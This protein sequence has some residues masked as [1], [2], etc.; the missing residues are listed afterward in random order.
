[1]EKA[2]WPKR[3]AWL[4]F[5]YI[6]YDAINKENKGKYEKNHG[7]AKWPRRKVGGKLP[8]T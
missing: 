8:P 6:L 2:M 7:K 3:N 5:S 1:M 4:I